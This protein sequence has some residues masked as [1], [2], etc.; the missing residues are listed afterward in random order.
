MPVELPTY[1]NPSAPST[2][3]VDPKGKSA[4]TEYEVLATAGGKSLVLLKPKT[5]RTHQ[6]RVHMRYLNTPITGDRVYGKAADRLYLHAKSL[7]ITIPE[8]DR[9]TFTSPLPAEFTQQF[10]GVEL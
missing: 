2:F 3:R 10:P 9:R 7:E 5:G 8:G 4:I 6:L 1:S